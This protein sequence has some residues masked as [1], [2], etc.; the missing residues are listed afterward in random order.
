MIGNKPHHRRNV[1]GTRDHAKGGRGAGRATR[2]PGYTVLELLVVMLLFAIII[3]ILSQTYISFIRLYHKMAYSS[4]LQQ[5]LRYFTEYTARLARNT[6]V[7]FSALSTAES[8]S[9]TLSFKPENGLATV[10]KL[11]AYGDAWCADDATV[12]CLLLSKDGGA[13]WSPLTSKHVNV[14]E[15]KAVVWPKLSP[16]ELSPMTGDYY[17]DTQPMATV[18]LK[19]MYMA[20]LEQERVTSDVQTTISSRVYVR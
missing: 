12:R 18:Y 4:L 6:P 3:T 11:S 8:V 15:F 5:D 2:L 7:D 20:R 9:S 1:P 10:I 13:S 16:F 17:N 19:L 14:E